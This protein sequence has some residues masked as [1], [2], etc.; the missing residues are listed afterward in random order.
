MTPHKTTWSVTSD[1]T[2]TDP[3]AVKDTTGRG[4]DGRV[5]VTCGVGVAVSVVEAGAKRL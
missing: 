2:S 4:G 5:C 3:G 1:P